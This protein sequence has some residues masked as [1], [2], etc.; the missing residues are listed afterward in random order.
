MGCCTSKQQTDGTYSPSSFAITVAV[1]KTTNYKAET[2][3]PKH[4]EGAKVLVV[5]TDDGRLKMENGKVH[6]SALN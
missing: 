1:K 5:C 4:T 3:S 6:K 2:Y